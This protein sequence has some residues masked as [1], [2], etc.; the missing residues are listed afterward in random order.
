VRPFAGVLTVIAWPLLILKMSGF[1]RR[2]ARELAHGK[3]STR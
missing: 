2:I 1:K 3:R